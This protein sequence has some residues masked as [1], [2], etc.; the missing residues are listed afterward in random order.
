MS[1]FDSI[2]DEIS[3]PCKDLQAIF[4]PVIAAITDEMIFDGKR[5]LEQLE[6]GMDHDIYSGCSIFE[7]IV[8]LCYCSLRKKG[9]SPI[10]F[11]A[12]YHEYSGKFQRFH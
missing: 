8:V 7:M 10:H 3:K 6:Y 11:I 12:L 4:T 2:S 9:V 5:L 1:D